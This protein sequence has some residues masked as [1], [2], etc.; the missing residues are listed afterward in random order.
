MSS[1]SFTVKEVLAQVKLDVDEIKDTTNKILVHAA[2][3][4]GKIAQAQVDVANIQA[5]LVKDE[6]RI[7][8]L[9][10]WQVKVLTYGA[11]AGFL[12]AIV[13]EVTFRLIL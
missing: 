11:V 2:A 1:D 10:K 12:G 5:K 3:T 6:G 7:D 8:Q 13:L 9:E 4:N